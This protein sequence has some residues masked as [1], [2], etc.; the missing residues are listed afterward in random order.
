MP[1]GAIV[2]PCLGTVHVPNPVAIY[3]V[4]N[5][6]GQATVT[7]PAPVGQGLCGVLITGQYL[8]FVGGACSVSLSDAIAITIGN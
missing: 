8:E 2:P 5:A 7:I 3:V 1:L 6:L 4:V